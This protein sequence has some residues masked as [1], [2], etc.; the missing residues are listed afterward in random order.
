M[1]F[2]KIYI[3]FIVS[4]SR[5]MLESV[6]EK[7]HLDKICVIIDE[8]VSEFTVLRGIWRYTGKNVIKKEFT[9]IKKK[10]Q[11]NLHALFVAD[12]RGTIP[13]RFRIRVRYVQIWILCNRSG[14]S[15]N[16]SSSNS[17]YSNRS[18]L[19]IFISSRDYVTRYVRSI[20]FSLSSRGGEKD[21]RAFPSTYDHAG[22]SV[23]S[24]PEVAA[25][26]NAT[27]I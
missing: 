14:G 5:D 16:N 15:R 27:I 4:L 26:E 13:D 6:F 25:R 20:L 11:E 10:F 17:R 23:T 12:K 2:H 22:I 21:I 8:R 9:F 1:R 3:I 24:L 19:G 7:H 18:L